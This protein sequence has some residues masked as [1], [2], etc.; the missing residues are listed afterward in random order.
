MCCSLDWAFFP[1]ANGLRTSATTRTGHGLLRY[2]WSFM[3]TRLWI[4]IVT[5]LAAA[6][7]DVTTCYNMLKQVLP[8]TEIPSSIL[9]KVVL[10]FD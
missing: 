5:A 8:Q 9:E 10:F 4:R 7:V 3:V 2:L 6:H 1:E